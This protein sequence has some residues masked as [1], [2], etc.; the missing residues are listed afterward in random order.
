VESRSAPA[1][2]IV[3]NPPLDGTVLGRLS[4]P[5]L[6][7]S[8]IVVEG[9][10]DGDLKHAVGHIPGTALPGGTGNLS[11]AGHRDTY[12]RPLRLIRRGDT[13]AP[14]TL[15]SAYRYRVVWTKV[16]E[17]EDVQVLDPA[18]KDVL[19]LVTCFPFN[20]VGAA[21]KRFIVRAERLP[22]VPR[23]DSSKESLNNFNSALE[24]FGRRMKS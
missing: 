9:V 10:E 8:V 14:D 20:Y 22:A 7:I 1:P 11:I 13:I 17:P 24:K 19:T 21:P 23:G 5:R 3:V 4:V 6:E 2:A 12:F 16:V 15:G 18:G